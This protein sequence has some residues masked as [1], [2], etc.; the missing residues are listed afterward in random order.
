M[1]VNNISVWGVRRELSVN[2]KDKVFGFLKDYKFY[3]FISVFVF[4]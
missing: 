3:N 4:G 1:D 2:F